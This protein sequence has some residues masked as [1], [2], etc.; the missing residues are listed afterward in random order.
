VIGDIIEIFGISQDPDTKDY[1]MVL[2]YANGGDLNNWINNSYKDF[3]WLSK[4][5]ILIRIIM[6]LK[7]IHQK[8]IIHRDFHPGNILF[9][10]IDFCYD[11]IYITDMGLCGEIGAD[12]SNIYGVM[13]YVAPEVLRG[14]PYT[15][16]ADIYSFGMIMYFVATGSQ[17]FANYAHDESLVPKICNGIRPEINEP[18]APKFYIDLMKKCWDSNPDNRPNATEIQKTIRLFGFFDSSYSKYA[19]D[20]SIEKEQQQY[21]IENKFKEAEDYRKS[22]L[23]TF[24]K[25]IIHPQAIYKSRLLSSNTYSKNLIYDFTK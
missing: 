4:I 25:N 2:Q 12:E 15:Q 9:G 24:R 7:T 8:Q 13:P 16:A 17:P 14:K 1:V 11:N 19:L 3:D 6:G 23:F 5:N 21:E 10:S 22:H 20:L 18:E